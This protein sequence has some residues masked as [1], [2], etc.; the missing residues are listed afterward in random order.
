MF[1]DEACHVRKQKAVIN[2]V[3]QQEH[4]AR[5]LKHM[6]ETSQSMNKTV[7]DSQKRNGNAD[8]GLFSFVTPSLD[9]VFLY[10]RAEARV[11]F[12]NIRIFAVRSPRGRIKSVLRMWG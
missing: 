2:E 9:E 3:W 12:K 5:A 11:M 7:G 1:L 6:S 10:V 4:C 8:F